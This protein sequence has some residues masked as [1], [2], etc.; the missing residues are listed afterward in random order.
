MTTAII[1]LAVALAGVVA[2]LVAG[3][4]A[5]R[6]RLDDLR[7]ADEDRLAAVRSLDVVTRQRDDEAARAVRA[8]RERDAAIAL[9][10]AVQRDRNDTLTLEAARAR[11]A[12]AADP[13]VLAELLA[14]PLPGVPRSDA[15]GDDHRDAG[16]DAVRAADAAGAG[17]DISDG[18]R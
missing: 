8:E 13:A 10:V 17:G 14:E 1:A 16:A 15:A 6:G 11:V 3:A 2:A 9:S 18:G 4:F 7:L 12:A 5:Y